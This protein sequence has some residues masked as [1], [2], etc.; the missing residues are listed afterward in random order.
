MGTV[1]GCTPINQPTFN[2]AVKVIIQWLIPHLD[3][4]S[5]IY[6]FKGNIERNT[7]Y[8]FLRL[9]WLSEYR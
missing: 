7:N 3:Y 4:P 2:L 9:I 6:R 8:L 5:Q 1:Y